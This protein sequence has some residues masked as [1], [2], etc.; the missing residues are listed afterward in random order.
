VSGK[1]SQEAVDRALEA[2]AEG[3]MRSHPEWEVR[4]HRPGEAATPGAVVLPAARED[5]VEAILGH[6]HR[7]GDD[8][9]VD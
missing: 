8:D 5:D 4:V 2:L 6:S 9:P 3:L 1:P 7:R